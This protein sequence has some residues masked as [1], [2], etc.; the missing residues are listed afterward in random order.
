MERK[1]APRRGPVAAILAA[2]L[3]QGCPA[4][5]G[6]NAKQA[7]SATAIVPVGAG[8]APAVPGAPAWP[9]FPPTPLV[10]WVPANA[11]SWP[12]W[13]TETGFLV[14][15]SGAVFGSAWPCGVSPGIGLGALLIPS[16]LIGT[17]LGY[18]GCIPGPLPFQPIYP[19]WV[20]RPVPLP[21]PPPAGAP[22]PAPV[23]PKPVP[24]KVPQPKPGD[25]IQWAWTKY[26]MT[27]LPVPI[28]LNWPADPWMFSPWGP[29][30]LCPKPPAPDIP[31]YPLGFPTADG[32]PVS[33]A[34][35]YVAV[36]RTGDESKVVLFDFLTRTLHPPP[37]LDDFTDVTSA[38]GGAGVL[39]VARADPA[40]T[41]T[42]V[43]LLTGGLDL[44]PELVDSTPG[45]NGNFDQRAAHIVYTRGPIGER[46]VAIF[47]R[48][49][50]MINTLQS[51]NDSYQDVFTPNVDAQSRYI[52]FTVRKTA[53]SDLDI[54]IYDT[55]TGLVDPLPVVNTPAD[56]QGPF[57]D[58]SARWMAYVS[59]EGG[60]PHALIYDRC[61]DAI[62]SL[63][64]LRHLGPVQKVRLTRD[65]H[66]L[67]VQVLQ[68][69]RRRVY[70]Y[71]RTA[72]FID[73]VPELNETADETFF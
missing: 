38:L 12:I 31:I 46:E 71:L 42:L 67:A 56:E 14:G 66:I 65:G 61:T 72:G 47:D 30:A 64:E 55:I 17:L 53:E 33:R 16:R 44:L 11:V 62:D 5:N 45:A 32:T 34:E 35:F 3:T 28:S 63:P 50:R 41:L 54:A 69:G 27:P 7:A 4:D 40:Q 1:P 51:L 68:N 9:F 23:P 25:V 26:G 57:F 15:G 29:V 22:L 20:P 10:D 58:W 70:F 18:P 52:A 39:L 21:P 48:R 37:G 2:M 59:N 73:P 6:L 19:V 24:V 43:D 8:A 36:Q 49:M 60:T 13:P